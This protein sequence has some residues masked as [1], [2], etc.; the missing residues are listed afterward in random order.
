MDEVDEV[1]LYFNCLGTLDGTHIRVNVPNAD[2]PRY[3]TRKSEI[4]TNV[5]GLCSQD[6]QF[7]YVLSGWEGS[8]H[9]ARVLR[10]AVTKSNVLKVPSGFYY[11]VDSGYANCP[12]F[13]APFRG[14]RYHLSSWADGHRPETPEEFFNMK[15][16]SARN[17]IERTFGLPKIHWKILASPSFYSIATQRRIINAC[18]LLHNFIRWEMIEDPAEDE[19]EPT[20]LEES[21]EDDNEHIVAVQPTN[22][23]TQFRQ[24]LAVNMFNMS[25]SQ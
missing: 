9:D 3:R 22:E 1:R 24:E 23:W 8:A 2:R 20:S 15:H 11:L 19:F 4:T 21:V 13:L 25:Q 6:M 18:C 17:V 16:A 5:L 10:D 7:I 14:Q 12:G